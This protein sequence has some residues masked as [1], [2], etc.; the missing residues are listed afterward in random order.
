MYIYMYMQL[1]IVFA[2]P[3]HSKL[4]FF[5]EVVCVLDES[6]EQSEKDCTFISCVVV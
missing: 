5:G 3:V 6:K 2:P 4:S 1:L